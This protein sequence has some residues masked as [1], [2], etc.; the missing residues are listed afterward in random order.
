M[1]DLAKGEQYPA[2]S[3]PDR[4]LE[5][6]APARAALGIDVTLPPENG[7]RRQ[8]ALLGAGASIE[9]VFRSEVQ[10]TQSSY[11]AVKTAP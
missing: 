6:T 7:A 10:L 2:A 9:D 11:A 1:I 4:F 8:R 5:W 3:L